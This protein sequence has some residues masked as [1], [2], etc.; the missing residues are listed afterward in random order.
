MIVTRGKGVE[1]RHRVHAAV[2]GPVRV[3]RHVGGTLFPVNKIGL[4]HITGLFA[5]NERVAVFQES[6]AH[7]EVATILG[8]TEG[9]IKSLQHRALALEVARLQVGDILVQKAVPEGA[10]RDIDLWKG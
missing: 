4:E 9:A 7:G 6:P 10:R 5:K 3:V 8:K 1:S 2:D